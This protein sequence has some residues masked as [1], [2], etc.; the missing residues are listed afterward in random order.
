M[1]FLINLPNVFHNN[2]ND[3]KYTHSIK[4]QA[5]LYGKLLS[6]PLLQ[7]SIGFKKPFKIQK[8]LLDAKVSYSKRK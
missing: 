5:T 1:K 2:G 3:G 7:I 8:S 4:G 6:I